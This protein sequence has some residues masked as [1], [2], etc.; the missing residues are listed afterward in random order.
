[1]A[2]LG[3]AG[4][5]ESRF[6]TYVDGLASAFGCADR[7]APFRAYCTGLILPGHPRVGE[8]PIKIRPSPDSPL[9]LVRQAGYT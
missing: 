5:I 2:P 6:S 9:T 7:T 4:S 8:P 3:A 1:M